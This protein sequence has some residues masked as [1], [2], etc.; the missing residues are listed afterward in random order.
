M[1]NQKELHFAFYKELVTDLAHE[2]GSNR[3][4]AEL[5]F[6]LFVTDARAPN[7]TES[8]N[9]N[10]R[11]VDEVNAKPSASPVN[12]RIEWI[13][14]HFTAEKKQWGSWDRGLQDFILD[15]DPPPAGWKPTPEGSTRKKLSTISPEKITVPDYIVRQYDYGNSGNENGSTSTEPPTTASDIGRLQTLLHA[16]GDTAFGLADHGRSHQYTRIGE[17]YRWDGNTFVEE[18]NI[19]FHEKGGV[20]TSDPNNPS[21]EYTRIKNEVLTEM[22]N[23]IPDYYSSVPSWISQWFWRFEKDPTEPLTGNEI[24]VYRVDHTNLDH[25]VP[26]DMKMTFI[27]FYIDSDPQP[28]YIAW[29]DSGDI[30]L[31]GAIINNIQDYLI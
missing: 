12:Q 25:N 8:L 31:T 9:M 14:E 18:Y 16:G 27:L 7:L 30:E 4:F 10:F 21:S 26:L 19:R 22:A 5:L 1:P 6:D 20:G 17:N 11:I 23:E 29:F 2:A 24:D 13:E 28:D 3:E 15:L